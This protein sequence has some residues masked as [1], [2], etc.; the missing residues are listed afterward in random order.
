MISESAP[1][2]VVELRRCAELARRSIDPGLNRTA[3]GAID[4]R[5]SCLHASLLFAVLLLKLGPGRPVFRG[6]P[7]GMGARG[8]D[9]SWY[10]HYWL[11]VGM[12]SGATYV[13][14]ITADQFG[15]EP[16][17]LMPVERSR[18]RYRAG[19]QAFVDRAVAELAKALGCDSLFPV[20]TV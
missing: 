10:G 15:Y 8:V 2:G 9:G 1:A 18:E 13:V 17:V 3:A 12:P 19:E 4:S 7:D 16:V 20:E 6:G 11:E 14:D 5:G